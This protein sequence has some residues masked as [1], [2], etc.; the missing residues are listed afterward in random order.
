MKKGIWVKGICTLFIWVLASCG[1]NGEK[2]SNDGS[3]SESDEEFSGESLEGGAV[4]EVALNDETGSADIDFS[5][6]TDSQRFVLMIHH[7]DESG[8]TDGFNL[9]SINEMAG[10]ENLKG[11][12]A[13]VDDSSG[14]LTEDFHEWLRNEEAGLDD[15]ARL[16]DPSGLKAA[17]ALGEPVLGSTRSFKVINSFGGG[18]SYTTVTAVLRYK[19]ENF[20]LYIDDRNTGGLSDDDLAELA[21]PFNELIPEEKGLFGAPSDVNGDGHFSILMTQVVNQIGGSSGGIITGFNYAV[22]LFSDSTYPQS[23]KQEI[24]YTFV[25]DPD[26]NFGTPISKSFALGN[27][28]PGVLPHEFQHMINFNM[29]Y[30][31]NDGAA[32]SAWLNEGAAHLAE[33]IYSLNADSYMEATGIENF[34]RVAG[35]LRDIDAICFSC[36]ASLYQ[37]GGAYLFMRYLY[38][39]AEKGDLLGAASGAELIARLLDTD[40]TGVANVVRAAVG[41]DAPVAPAFRRLLGRFGLA[42]FMSGTGLSADARL[43]FEGINLRASQDDNRGTVLDGPA[44]RA[45][46]SFPI[47][48]TIAGGSIAYIG[49][50]G[51]DVGRIGGTLK[52]ELGSPGKAG[53]FLIQT[54]L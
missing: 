36:G 32:E 41:E 46:G 29:H 40:A 3:G 35:Y 17:T 53:A 25:P 7:Y 6:V 33:D 44:V 14:D 31:V 4:T 24:F 42:V 51:E 22:D 1:G 30:F 34:A 49:L 5:A 37:R 28:L 21:Q 9:G 12:S 52:L 13:L 18:G 15:E 26:G 45:P 23:N 8:R 20:F 47:S 16:D 19:T 10:V 27:I 38:E 39:Q 54:G 43:E 2:F 50:K 11:L 48:R